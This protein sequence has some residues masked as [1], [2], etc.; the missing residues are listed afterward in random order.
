[1]D[2]R[3]LRQ[4][5]TRLLLGLGGLAL[6]GG[7]GNCRTEASINASCQK[8]CIKVAECTTGA[9]TASVSSDAEMTECVTDCTGGLTITTSDCASSLSLYAS[10]IDAISCSSGSEESLNQCIEESDVFSDCGISTEGTPD[11]GGDECCDSDDP[12]EFADDGYCDCPGESWDAAD[13]S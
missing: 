12:C 5:L 10:C 8:I 4:L 3:K 1:M 2:S 11:S 7:A 9:G 13:C 6:L